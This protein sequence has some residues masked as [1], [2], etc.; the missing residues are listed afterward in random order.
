MAR[1]TPATIRY[2]VDVGYGL[3]TTIRAGHTVEAEISENGNAWWVEGNRGYLVY[4]GEFEIVNDVRR[5]E[6]PS[7]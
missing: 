5:R 1:T 2:T 6:A 4:H 3:S 7:K